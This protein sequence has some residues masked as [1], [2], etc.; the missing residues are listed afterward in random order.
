MVAR[1]KE[2]NLGDTGLREVARK[3][4][5]ISGC[6]A[7]KKY[8]SNILSSEQANKKE[9]EYQLLCGYLLANKRSRSRRP[10]NAQKLVGLVELQKTCQNTDI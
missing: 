4:T 2:L 1:L 6:F 10:M 7:R 9:I 3:T 8:H 5:N